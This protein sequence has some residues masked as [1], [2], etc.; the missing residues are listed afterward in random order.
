MSKGRQGEKK[1][2]KRTA[3]SLKEKT[4]QFRRKIVKGEMKEK[5][6]M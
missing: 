2:T 5:K 6:R 1:Q 3:T 4:R